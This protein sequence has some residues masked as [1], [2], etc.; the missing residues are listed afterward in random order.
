MNK[1]VTFLKKYMLDLFLIV[2]WKKKKWATAFRVLKIK[3][4]IQASQV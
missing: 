4:L 1:V 2:F 3:Q